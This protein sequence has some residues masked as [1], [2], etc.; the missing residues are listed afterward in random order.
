MDPQGEF[1]V[2]FG[3]N[4]TADAMAEKARR[5]GVAGLKSMGPLVFFSSVD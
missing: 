1:A 2:F 3:K 4:Y 5:L